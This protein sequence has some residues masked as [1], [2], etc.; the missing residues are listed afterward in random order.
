MGAA[1]IISSLALIAL[2]AVMAY[3]AHR[4]LPPM[5]NVLVRRGKKE[6]QAMSRIVEKAAR[7]SGGRGGGGA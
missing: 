2:I 1:A 5:G 6:R 7:W 3:L 4:S